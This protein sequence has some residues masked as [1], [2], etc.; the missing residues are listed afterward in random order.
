MSQAFIN[1]VRKAN[2]VGESFFCTL[3]IVHL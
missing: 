2:G 3:Q 1:A